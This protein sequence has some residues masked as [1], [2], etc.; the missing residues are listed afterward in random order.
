MLVTIKCVIL[1]SMDNF[2]FNFTA[3]DVK[4]SLTLRDTHKESQSPPVT[5]IH[6]VSSNHDAK[7]SY[8]K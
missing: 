1:W 5:K 2:F 6:S 3:K 4:T 8:K 7:L